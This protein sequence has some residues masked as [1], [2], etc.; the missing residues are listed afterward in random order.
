MNFWSF[1][2]NPDRWIRGHIRRGVKQALFG[3]VIAEYK[4]ERGE[5]KA[6]NAAG[7]ALA[8]HNA[9]SMC[10]VY[11]PWPDGRTAQIDQI[12]IADSGIYVLEV[13]N[14]KGWIFG[15]ERNQYWTQILTTGIRGESI[16][17]RLYNPI[18]QNATHISCIRRNIRDYTVL[19]HSV[20]VFS[21]ESEFK[22]VTYY[23]S[24]VY[25]VYQSR[26]K[27]TL[28]D[29]D[30]QYK[31]MLSDEERKIL[32]PWF[33]LYKMKGYSEGIIRGESKTLGIKRILDAVNIPIE[34][35]I[36]IGD[37]ANDIEM[38]MNVGY[39]IAMSNA[40][41]ELKQIAKAT[42][43]NCYCNGVGKAIC[44]YVLNEDYSQKG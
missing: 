9:I 36:G 1:I 38:I 27:S 6:S 12:I 30:N 19:I 10:D 43:D 37:S 35:S 39:G 24:D 5:H 42:T 29:I 3:D 40:V 41:T 14:Y 8:G 32:H 26:L 34:N 20:I 7:K 18:K 22:D 31:G 25:V 28:R 33:F 23:S 17:N 11:L 16:K 21:D 15:N 44:K 2:S 13:K 4:G